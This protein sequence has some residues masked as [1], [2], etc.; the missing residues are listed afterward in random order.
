MASH[1]CPGCGEG[2]VPAHMLACNKC[3]FRLPKCLRDDIVFSWRHDH[4]NHRHFVADAIEWFV[5][6]SRSPR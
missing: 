5:E 3:W 4:E 2:R 1:K 6:N